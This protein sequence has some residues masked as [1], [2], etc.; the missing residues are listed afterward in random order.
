MR[1]ELARSLVPFLLAAFLG[2]S[3]APVSRVAAQAADETILF[4]EDFQAGAA[5]GWDLEPGWQLAQDNGEWF[6]EGSG[7][8]W[9]RAN[10]PFPGDF[11]LTFRVRLLRGTIH[12]VYRLNDIGRYFIGFEAGGSALNR[13]EWPDTFHNGLTGA[14]VAHP[15]NTWHEVEISGE[16]GHLRF[17]VDGRQEWEYT[18]PEPL[19]AGSF[20]FETLDGASAQVDDIVVY[21]PS[22]ATQVPSGAVPGSTGILSWVPSVGPLGGLGYDVRMHPKDP[23]RMYVTDAYAGV[24]LSSDGGDTWFPSSEGITTRT[25]DSGDA[26]PVFCLTIDPNNPDI[27]WAGTQFQRGIFK[28]I[29]SGQTWTR[30]EQGVVER[31]GITFR[32]FSVDPRDS[33][34]VYT[35]A[36]ISSWAW[37]GEPRTGRE[38]DLVRGVIYKTTDGGDHWAAIWRGD[39]LA[40]YI[41]IDPRD[42]DVL[43]ISTG[44]FD[45]EAANSD[46]GAGAP[47]GVGV[48]K[49]TDGGRT[50]AEFNVGLGNL[51]VGSL[52]M[53]PENPDIL[54][55][56]TGNNQYFARAGAYLSRDGGMSWQHV[57]TDDII[58]SVEFS[59]FD[60]RIAYAGSAQAVY[61]SEDG[62]HMWRRVS[63]GP[64]NGW[65][66]PGV[67]A[68]FPIDFQVDPRNP[69]R[70]FANNYGGG[71]FLSLN[72]GNTWAV[73]SAGY[74]GAQVRDI[75]VDPSE[76]GR[77]VAA[78]RSGIFV[79]RDGGDLWEGLSFAPVAS[80]EWTAVAI[81][82][83]NSDHILAA[84][85][86]DGLMVE[87]RDAGQ[88]WRIAAHVPAGRMGW[89]AIAF[90]PLDPDT[91]Y[92]GT[93]GFYSAGV[94]DMQMPAAGA[95][96]SHDG[97]KT[98]SPANSGLMQDAHVT[99]IA[100]DAI[101]PNR[102]F[103]ATSNHGILRSVD[104]GATWTEAN[105]GMRSTAALSVAFSPGDPEIVFAGLWRGGL[106][107]SEDG[108]LSWRASSAG[109]SPEASVSDVVFDPANAE[110]LYASDLHSGVF[111]SEGGG[112]V[113]RAISSGLRMRAVNA[114][115]LSGDGSHLYAAAE[116]GG[117]MRLDLKGKPPAAAPTAV[118][119]PTVRPNSTAGPSPLPT[120]K[121]AAETSESGSLPLGIAFAGGAILGL[122]VILVL[123]RQLKR[124]R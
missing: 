17:V 21:G 72:G 34:I 53:H 100:V 102:L 78:A 81:D 22:A 99:G 35:A 85:N 59:A 88:T 86:W 89:R 30:K 105:Q 120:A 12:L 95:Y 58:T 47:G 77:V 84:T 52:F 60:S 1:C 44:I 83:A 117:V 118:T 57:L 96:V 116:G 121:P 101:D 51:Y 19:L 65:G 36:E 16:G 28:S 42:S 37:A 25:G 9:A 6:L 20:A 33:D 15:L 14:S 87:S 45:R 108:G 2:A 123:L 98:W 93:A 68:G 31:D 74:T 56:G 54:L 11:R 39:N 113:W 18:D 8:V 70:L 64:E 63:G 7:H 111:R 62:G 48:V 66:P 114:L 5:R 10:Q 38:F 4:Q 122:G 79:S 49:S 90:A 26:I 119:L 61:R 104:G 50:W 46:P 106:Y 71:N 94:F 82:P 109:M 75:A 55:A 24:F 76:P 41:W 69:D 115:A 107:R 112:E 124:R 3:L 103:V 29:D 73:A 110:V 92:A 23:D 32:G 27:I 40:R 43:Y 91:V 67:R 97:G 13:Q 80:L